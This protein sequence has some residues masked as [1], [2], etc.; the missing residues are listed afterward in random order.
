MDRTHTPQQKV[1]PFHAP[2]IY[3]RHSRRFH[4][5][6]HHTHTHTHTP[7]GRLIDA[8]YTRRHGRRST[9]RSRFNRLHLTTD[10]SAPT[11]NN[12]SDTNKNNNGGRDGE[13]KGR[14]EKG[15]EGKEGYV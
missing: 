14:E 7:E 5:P 3:I 1:P 6:M 15:R 2:Y 10:V 12:N 4:H 9:P 13:G 11:S 8:P